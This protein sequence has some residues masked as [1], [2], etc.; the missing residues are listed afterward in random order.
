MSSKR[1]VT[2]VR[3][4]HVA[5]DASGRATHYQGVVLRGRRELATTPVM[6][7]GIACLKAAERLEAQYRAAF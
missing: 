6:T 5:K 4:D 2:R 7:D 3:I 1:I